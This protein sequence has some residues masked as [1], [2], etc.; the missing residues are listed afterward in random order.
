MAY[1]C[2]LLTTDVHKFTIRT[3]EPAK[4]HG[5]KYYLVRTRWCVVRTR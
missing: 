3:T 4:G 2:L 5:E 1:L